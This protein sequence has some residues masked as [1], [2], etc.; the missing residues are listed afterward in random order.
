MTVETRALNLIERFTRIKDESSI[1]RLEIVVGQIELQNQIES[2]LE[3]ID[4]NK[5]RSYESFNK[6]V[7]Q[8]MKQRKQSIR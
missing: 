6:D 3:D 8:W 2:S 5:V 1:T 7:D 4:N